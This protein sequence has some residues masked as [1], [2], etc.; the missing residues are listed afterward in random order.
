M[1]NILVI[2]FLMPILL[3]AQVRDTIQ[4]GRYAIT[5]LGSNDYVR[6][7]DVP[8]II[9]SKSGVLQADELFYVRNGASLDTIS[10]FSF[11]ANKRPAILFQRGGK[12]TGTI[13][14]NRNDIIFGS[15]GEG[16]NPVITGFTDITGWTNEGG[17]IYSKVLSVDSSPEIVTVNGVQ[18][19]MGRTPNSN[20]YNPSYND[21]FHID[22]YSGTTQITDTEIPA[23]TAN[24]TGADAVVRAKNHMYFGR[25]PITGHSSNTITFTNANNYPLDNGFGYFIQNDLRTLDQF[26]EWYYGGGKFYMYF[27]GN[28]PASYTVKV[29][30]RN[31]LIDVNN[32]DFVTIKNL[33]ME[34]ANK[35]AVSTTYGGTSNNLTVKHCYFDFNNISVYGHTSPEMRLTNNTFM[36]S[37]GMAIYQHWESD[38]TY[39]AYNTIDSTGLVI[40]AGLSTGAGITNYNHGKGLMLTYAKQVRS[41]KRAIIEHNTILNS[42]YMGIDFSG[43]S[44]IVRN[45]FV[46]KFNIIQSDG[47]GIYYG[48]QDNLNKMYVQDN[49]VLNGQQQT[50]KL[51]YPTGVIGNNTHG[52]YFDYKSNGGLTAYGNTVANIPLSGVYIHMTQNATVRNNTI[53]NCGMS[54]KYQELE[55]YSM[56]VRNNA[57]KKNIV[58]NDT[59]NNY[60]IWARS[61]N[62]D[63]NLFGALDSNYFATDIRHS[64][65]VGTAVAS[66]TFDYRNFSGWKT[67]SSQDSH[68]WFSTNTGKGT[69]F[70]YNN[71]ATSKT[72]SVTGRYMTA[73]SVVY[74]NTSYTLQPWKSIIL[75]KDT[76]SSITI[77]SL[78]AYYPLNSTTALNDQIGTQ[79]GTNSGA[80]QQTDDYDFNN[81]SDYMY[82][83]V[84]TSALNNYAYSVSFMVNLDTLPSVSARM[85]K[86]FF[87]IQTGPSFKVDAYISTTNRL[88]VVTRNVAA[89]TFT[90][91]TGANSF[92]ATGTW[93]H[94]I[95]NIPKVGQNCDIF[96]N[97]TAASTGTLDETVT[98]TDRVTNYRLYLSDYLGANG[99][100][101]KIKK[102]RVR[103]THYTPSEAE[104]QYNQDK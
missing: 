23:A 47:G 27:G 20:R 32:R 84:N 31:K 62:N 87:D 39:I 3:S 104:Y 46:N 14:V 97:G 16:T 95:I 77:D 103:N 99:H 94:V 82:F 55:G 40:S 34:G 69:I 11:T 44:M 58:V 13:T 37:S 100:R 76:V 1:K 80:T 78:Y 25:F 61:L 17:G 51:G 73:D 10:S 75:M 66:W 71:T 86:L 89:T 2:L 49:I 67:Y 50:D 18:Y 21:F 98:G 101:G 7:I 52:I 15:W 48:Q 22:S 41:T 57:V 90:T 54:F 93:Y 79:H 29:S 38:G 6:E 56:P 74:N 85:Y 30:A 70:D 72:V 88:T 83:P 36:R 4:A 12:W 9:L 45:N 28:N 68:S 60:L 102:F 24:W 26:G 63:F 43:D 65:P 91:N 53:Y 5:T 35:Y 33:K 19:A 8:T 59:T 42:G 81:A 92:S 96:I 64:T